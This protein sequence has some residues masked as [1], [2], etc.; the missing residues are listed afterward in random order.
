MKKLC[1][2]FFCISASFVNAN[3]T[4]ELVIETSKTIEEVL[5]KEG[6]LTNNV[7]E[8]IV[9]S[10]ETEEE[11]TGGL[12]EID[13][14]ELAEIKEEKIDFPNKIDWEVPEHEL[15]EKFR[16]QF[17][18]ERGKKRLSECMERG[19]PYRKY[20][21]QK[22]IEY[23]MPL[24]LEFLPVIES[25]FNINAVS[26]SGATGMWQFMKNSMAP[27][28][29]ANEWL[30]ERKDPWL[31]TD[32]ALKKLKENYNILNDWNLALAAYN[33][34]L[35]AMKKSMKRG[36]SNDYWYL[37]DNDFLKKETKYYIPKFLAIAQ[38]LSNPEYFELDL[39]DYENYE[40][41]DFAVIEVNRA[42]DVTM[43]ASELDIDKSKIK[44]LNPA[45]NYNI[46]PPDS[47]YAFRVPSDKEEEI[48]NLLSDKSKLLI[49][50][51]IYRI[52]SGDTL[53]EL[54]VHYDVSIDMIKQNNPGLNERYLK[55]GQKLIIPALKDVKPYS[56]PVKN[57]VKK[58]P[59]ADNR[60]FTDTYVV[61]QDD[62]LW[63]I[64]M[65][66]NVDYEILAE[67]NNISP[68]AVLRVGS[69]L[70]VPKL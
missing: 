66:Y 20:I 65:K 3:T 49:R 25:E 11:G 47:K 42:I 58:T 30:D 27:Y 1:F 8:E 5:Q 14:E 61:K 2:I 24:C 43:I 12:L 37:L 39:P 56:K 19:L 35:G 59:K 51:Y 57:V 33:C 10:D 64:S 50:Y 68:N 29:K 67:K 48:K 45:L 69:T 38:I 70:K 7:T 34:G 41:N 28:M 62:T 53:S 54:A 23:E 26:R 6:I 4:E 16:S 52:N 15:V 60:A 40:D 18:T 21:R 46:T 44:F 31:S 36:D 9:D 63:G 55:I 32:A 13:E 17:S 22:L